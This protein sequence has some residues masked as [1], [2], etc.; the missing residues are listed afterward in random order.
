M[1]SLSAVFSQYELPIEWM[2]FRSTYAGYWH[3]AFAACRITFRAEESKVIRT[4]LSLPVGETDAIFG[5]S[6]AYV[7]ASGWGGVGWP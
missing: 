3:A 7:T 6:G 2:P 5:P 4:S 1:A